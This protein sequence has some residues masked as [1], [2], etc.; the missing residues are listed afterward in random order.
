M[1]TK[2][3]GIV[4]VAAVV[5]VAVVL[6]ITAGGGSSD[7]GGE[8]ADTGGAT[9]SGGSAVVEVL[10]P[11]D[12]DPAAYVGEPLVVNF[13]GSW[14]GPCAME[15]PDLAAFAQ[16]SGAQIV[17]VAVNDTE[18]DALAFLDEHGLSFPIVMD[19]NSLGADYGITGVPTTIFFDAEGQETER[20]VGAASLDQFNAALA[21]S[22]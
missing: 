9:G 13:F 3:L 18:E 14:C 2:T 1:K 5:A 4:I 20:L 6:A 7:G 19:D 10:A 8:P 12:F 22:Q 15:A 21:Q 17:G 16:Q 11:A